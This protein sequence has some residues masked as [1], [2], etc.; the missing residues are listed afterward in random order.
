MTF[1]FLT[2]DD[3]AYVRVTIIHSD[4]VFFVC[5]AVGW[6][7]F[8]AWSVS[9]YPQIYENFKRKWWVSL[10]LSYQYKLSSVNCFPIV[11]VCHSVVGL[12][13]DYVVLNVLGH[14]V[15]GMFNLGLY[16]IPSVQVC[17]TTVAVILSVKSKNFQHFS[18]NIT[19]SIQWALSRSRQMTSYFQCTLP[20]SLF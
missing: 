20:F 8:V 17:W 10:L 15:Y 2:S 9:F 12:N 1:Y 19:K 11:T 3:A 16:W 4:E 5:I 7:Y 13:L 18:S 14:F 6:I